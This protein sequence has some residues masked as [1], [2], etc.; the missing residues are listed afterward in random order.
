MVV[1]RNEVDAGAGDNPLK[2]VASPVCGGC[3]ADPA[4]RRT[5]LKGTFFEPSQA[6]AAVALAGVRDASGAAT[7]TPREDFLRTA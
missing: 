7:F 1:V 6:H 2:F 4:H 5:V 3:H